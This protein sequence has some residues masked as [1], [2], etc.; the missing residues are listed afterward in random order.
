[1]FIKLEGALNITNTE[2][3]AIRRN[4]VNFDRLT[5]ETIKVVA[6]KLLYAARAK[7]RNSDIID[8][9]SKVVADN[10]LEKSNVNDNEP[11]ISSPDITFDNKD[12]IYIARIVGQ[13]NLYK[14]LKYVELAS[15]GKTIPPNIAQGMNPAIQMLVDIAQAGPSYISMLKYVHKQAKSKK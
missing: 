15:Q 11:N 5:P 6:T 2:Y 10:N 3:K 12:L 13:Q 4:V 8:N 7:L 14:A 9:F 1:M